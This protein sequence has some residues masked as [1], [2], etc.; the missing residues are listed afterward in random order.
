[1]KSDPVYNLIQNDPKVKEALA[2]PKVMQILAK[3]Q[4]TGGLDFHEVA[5]EDPQ[6]ANKLM[7]LINKGVLNT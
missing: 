5:R 4:Q 6:T 1:M 7:F 2:D 3:L